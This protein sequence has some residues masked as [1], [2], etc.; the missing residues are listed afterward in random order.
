MAKLK[1]ERDRFDLE[2][3]KHDEAPR[4]EGVAPGSSADAMAEFF[5]GHPG[6]KGD[7]GPVGERGITGERGLPGEQGPQGA[8][9]PEGIPGVDGQDGERG[10]D[11][12]MGERGATGIQGPK[13]DPGK[14]GLVWKGAYATGNQYAPGDAVELDGSSWIAQHPTNSRPQA[15]NVDWHVLALKGAGGVVIGSTKSYGPVNVTAAHVVVTPAGSLSSTNAQAAL[16]ELQ[17]DADLAISEASDAAADAATAFALASAAVVANVAIAGATKTKVTYDAKGLVTAGADA[18]TA[19]IA[20]SMNKRYVTD[21]QLTVVGNTSGTNSG[22]VSISTANGLSLVGQALSLSTAIA[23]GANGALLGTDKTKL[24]A[25]S[26][27]NTGDITLTAVG[28]T[29]SANGASLSSQAL[30]LQPADATNPGVVTT[31]TQTFAGT[32][33][34]SGV[35]NC[36]GYVNLLN[37]NIVNFSTADNY[38]YIIRSATDTLRVGNG[39]ASSFRAGLYIAGTASGNDAFS[40]L[41]GAAFNFSTADANARMKRTAANVINA[42]GKLTA[43]SG[44]GV[45]NS[46]A[47]TTLGSV[48]KKMEIFDASGN[49]LGFIAI[50]D[51]IT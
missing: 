32:K 6:A 43:T 51:A 44:L 42:T 1:L 20:D 40:M 12:A 13:G 33:T 47:A 16:E 38:A 4:R 22:N 5:R 34:F 25:L 24:D 15:G 49:S 29:P 46:A 11:G 35:V 10:L 39:T 26:G 48:A 50:Y 37:G 23:A 2:K 7:Q 14:P 27:T 21:A 8:Q 17:T 30:T 18:T 9:G 3:R 41:D 28:S 31:G 36:Q 45:G 19:D